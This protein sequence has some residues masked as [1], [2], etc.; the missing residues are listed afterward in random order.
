MIIVDTA[1]A[2]RVRQGNPIRVALVGA[3]FSGRTVA[4]QIITG[5]PGLRLVAIANRTLDRAREA[6]ALAG[7]PELVEATSP[8]QLE[9]AMARGQSAVTTDPSLLCEAQGIEAIIETTGTVEFGARVVL[10]AVHHGKHVV[11]LNA[12][13]DATLGPVLKARADQAGVIISNTDGD[14]PGVAMNLAR[15]VRSIGLE[16]VV[17]GNLKGLYDPYRTPDTQ[18]AFAAQHGQKA[19]SMT[20]FADGTKL[21]MELTVLANALGFG[22][23][24]RDGGLLGWRP[25]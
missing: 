18:A 22:V 8:T 11:L 15:Y 12:E 25:S 14:E 2:A 16:P 4:Y 1:L 13:L 21:S 3:G 23:G 24:K 10:D 19:T 5:F 7:V 17:A 6:Y 9:Q 20:S